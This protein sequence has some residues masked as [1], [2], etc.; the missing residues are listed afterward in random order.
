LAISGLQVTWLTHFAFAQGDFAATLSPQ[1]VVPPLIVQ[2]G[3]TGAAEF[4]VLANGITY[5]VNASGYG[6]NNTG[7]YIRMGA[8]GENGPIVVHLYET[9]NPMDPISINGTIT[10]DRLEGPMEG[11]QLLDL[12]RAISNGTTYVNIHNEPS[13]EGEIRGQ[14][15]SSNGSSNLGGAGILFGGG[16][17]TA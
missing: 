2:E 14:I 12:V 17:G 1:E 8:P 16:N 11:K 9:E 6:D 13:D 3:A 4:T 7:G 15:R 10:A 5:S